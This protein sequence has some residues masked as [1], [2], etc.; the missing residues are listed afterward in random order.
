[1]NAAGFEQANNAPLRSGVFANCDKT[2]QPLRGSAPALDEVFRDVSNATHPARSGADC[3]TEWPVD[4]KNVGDALAL[5]RALSSESKKLVFWDAQ[6]RQLLDQERYGNEGVSRGRRR[7][8][9][10]AMSEEY[11]AEWGREIA[12]GLVPSGY[13]A[14]WIDEFQLLNGLFKICGLEHVGVVHWDGGRPGMGGR[15]RTVGGSLVFLQKPPIGVRAKTLPVRWVTKPM[16]RAVHF[17]TIRFP[18]SAHPHRKPIG[19]LAE[20][21]Q[22]VTE[23]GDTAVDPAAGSFVV[24]L[25]ALGCGPHF[26]GTDILPTSNGE[27][28]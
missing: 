11:I 10:P 5:L 19:L 26:L 15:I 25:A 8:T 3:N 22:A 23:P 20:I 28:I 14:R 21:I 12:R 6:Y 2:G 18:R 13:C 1:M 16:I 24:M 27:I 7:K 9:L 17:E 4:T